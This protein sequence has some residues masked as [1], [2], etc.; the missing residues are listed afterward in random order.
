[1]SP[2]TKLSENTARLYNFQAQFSAVIINNDH[3]L[4][5][6][7]RTRKTNVLSSAVSHDI[8]PIERACTEN[9][10]RLYRIVLIIQMLYIASAVTMIYEGLQA[11]PL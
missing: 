11:T 8:P 2:R 1:M 3:K 7:R 9:C 4:A 6:K 10:M 5:K